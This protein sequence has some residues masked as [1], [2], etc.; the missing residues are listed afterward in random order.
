MTRATIPPQAI[1]FFSGLE[2]NNNRD[3]FLANKKTYEDAVRTPFVSLIEEISRLWAAQDIPLRGGANT[4]FRI[5][6]DVRFSKDKSPYKAHISGLL[7]AS[8]SKNPVEPLVYLHMDAQGGFLAAG[9]WQPDTESLRHFRTKIVDEEEAFTELVSALEAEGL[10]L[11]RTSA[12]K[13]MPRGFADYADHPHSDCIKLKNLI[14]R[15][16]LSARDWSSDFL[17]NSILSFM[18]GSLPLLRFVSR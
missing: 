1:N 9:L 14:V 16:E 8:G 3:W 2:E 17:V 4:I 18:N 10:S 6:R 7:T 5:N 12:A 13:M 11:D 15:R